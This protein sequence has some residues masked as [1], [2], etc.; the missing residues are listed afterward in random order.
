M[1]FIE[2]RGYHLKWEYLSQKGNIFIIFS[3]DASKFLS[4]ILKQQQRGNSKAGIG[5]DVNF[6]GYQTKEKSK[7]SLNNSFWK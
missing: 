5:M 6:E 1:T 7:N 2:G 3:K 4:Q